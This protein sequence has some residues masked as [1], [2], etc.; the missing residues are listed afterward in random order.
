MRRIVVVAL[1][2]VTTLVLLFKP[3][4]HEQLCRRRP[5]GSADACADA[6]ADACAGGVGAVGWRTPLVRRLRLAAGR[7]GLMGPVV[8]H[9]EPQDHRDRRGGHLHR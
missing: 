9:A 8:V 5:L 1:S 4:E 3:H 6:R 7:V 2:T